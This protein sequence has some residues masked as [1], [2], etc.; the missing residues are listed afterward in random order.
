MANIM[1]KDF[2]KKP[3]G[4]LYVIATPIGNMEDITFRA[5]SILKLVDEVAAEDTRRSGRLLKHYGI[6]T[7]MT[8][9][10]EHNEIRRVPALL[11]KLS[12][13]SSI[14]LLSDAGTPSVSDPG[15]R[16]V[17]GSIHAKIPVVPIPGAS[18]PIAALSVSGL[19]CD[20]F[21]FFGFLDRK[22]NK[23]MQQLQKL[24]E[25]SNTLVFFESPHRISG[26]VDDMI[27]V[28][29]N[30]QAVICREMTKLHEEFLRGDLIQ[31]KKRLAE[32]DGLKGECTLLV[33]GKQDGS[34]V[35]SADLE[36]L[37]RRKLSAENATVS[38]VARDLAGFLDIPKKKI[39]EKAIEIKK[40]ND[41]N[42]NKTF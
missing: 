8:S 31:L 12:S 35:D 34:I 19:S 3:K 6:S 38:R 36:G 23:R 4:V 30:R 29:G 11:A 27:Q 18:A 20:A 15:F 25:D 26:L 40:E 13:G 37:I 33:E 32:K 21:S 24:S 5:V 7:K 2:N 1:D 22:K 16:L 42:Q 39:Y 10:H 14:A 41:Q 28:F 9:F 17:S